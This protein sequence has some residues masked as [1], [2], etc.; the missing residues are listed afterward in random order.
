MFGMYDTAVAANLMV[1]F[2]KCNNATSSIPC[3]SKA[4]IDKFLE[5]KYFIGLWNSE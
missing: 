5:F 1:V 4:E 3:K 2:D